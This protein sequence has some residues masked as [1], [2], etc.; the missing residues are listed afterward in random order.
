MSEWMGESFRRAGRVFHSLLRLG[1]IVRLGFP[2]GL[3]LSVAL[4]HLLVA[5]LFDNLPVVEHGYVV[6]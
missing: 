2:K 1:V 4:H 5:A 6:A 3:V